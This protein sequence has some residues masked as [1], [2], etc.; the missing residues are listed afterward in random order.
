MKKFFIFVITSIMMTKLSFSEI[1]DDDR[2]IDWTKAGY[3]GGGSIPVISSQ[4][5]KYFNVKDYGAKANGVDDD[6]TAFSSAITAAKT[7]AKNNNTI[8]VVY[9][10]E[11]EYLIKSKLSFQDC[12]GVVL[13]GEG[14]KKTKIY[15]QQSSGD[16]FE[17]VTYR[18]GNWVDVIS[19][20]QKGSTQI[21]V[22]DVSQFKVGDIAEIQQD[23]DPN[24][25]YTQSQWDQSWAQYAVGQFF[26]VVGIEGN[27]LII[28]PPLNIS[29]KEALHPQVRRNNLITNV[30]FEDFYV[31]R[32]N[33]VDSN[34]FYFKNAA[35]C[36]VRRVASYMTVKSHVSATSCLNLEVRECYFEDSYRHDGGG[37]G[38]GVELGFHV[39]NCLV[40]NNIF[41]RLRHSMMVH[42]G[43]NGNVFGY[44][45]SIEPFQDEGG[46]WTPCDIS[47]HGHYPFMNLFEGNIVQEVDFSDYWGPTGPGNTLFRNRVESEGIEVMDHSNYQ[48][49]IANEIAT[50]SS[51]GI[52]Y[53]STVDSTTLIIH[54]NN[55]KGTIQY[56]PKISDRNFPVSYYKLS[57]PSFY[58]QDMS[59]PSI[60]FDIQNGIIPAK[61][62]YQTGEYIP[63][64]NGGSSSSSTKTYKLNINV[65]PQNAG[66][67]TLTPPG[68]V[69][70]KGT[71]V[72]LFAKANTGWVF[73]R[74]SG[75]IT[76]NQN[77]I[78]IVMDSSKT[79][80]AIFVQQSTTT[81]PPQEYTLTV[82]INPSGAGSITLNPSGGVYV[83]GTTVTLTAVANSG[84]VFS[85]WSGDINTT[86]NP[87][88][89]VIDSDITIIANFN[90]IYTKL[91]AKEK[92]IL[93]LDDNSA[94]DEV[95]FGT[96]EEIESV[97][98]LDPK[99]KLVLK[100]EYMLDKNS[101]KNLNNGVYLFKIKFK[102]NT[103]KKGS[104]VILR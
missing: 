39:T 14:Y 63:E 34:T 21:V 13:K 41:K 68:G 73:D 70:T 35:N 37:H 49:I 10:P 31:E 51:V 67:V 32:K 101:A 15:F 84:W 12:D 33:N 28:D 66:T 22:S 47:L 24:I 1:L 97:E 88:S 19:G 98:I 76:G 91:E 58:P 56:D 82:N 87:I 80:T 25:M 27:T 79:I 86:E 30:G 8:A 20:Y 69:Y 59:W 40:E 90:K 2:H 83:A 71:E 50:T 85:S 78:T 45:Y 3:N 46:N 100:T 11:G 18:R 64:E 55:I 61:I 96:P 43:A 17:I 29:F 42:I 48:N 99:G 44:N 102:N 4:T 93:S 103:T 92:Y 26:R 23:N 16:C 53:D 36:W 60:G 5:Y 65:S 72:Q 75:D 89:I 7:Y 95:I 77:P 54:G 94:N 52:I 81:I 6:Y 57:K 9:V 104:L 62:R 38:Y 74:W